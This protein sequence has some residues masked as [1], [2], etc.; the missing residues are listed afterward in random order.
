MGDNG[1]QRCLWRWR[2]SGSDLHYKI[3]HLHD[4]LGVPDF[5]KDGSAHLYLIL[6]LLIACTGAGCSARQNN[7]SSGGMQDL[8]EHL[9]SW[10][11]FKQGLHWKPQV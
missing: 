9:V 4:H 5:Q 8:R 2:L 3:S 7:L 6:Q 10:E 1:L 11:I